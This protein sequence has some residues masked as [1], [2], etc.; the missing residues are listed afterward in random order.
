[1]DELRAAGIDN[2]NLDLMYALPGQDLAGAL[3]DIDTALA[4]APPHLSH[5]QLTMEPGTVFGALPPPDLPGDESAAL[6]MEQ[7]QARLA[8]AGF[9]HY[10]VSAYARAGAC[11]QH[12]LNYW[13]FG[14]YLG[15]GA[16]AHGKYTDLA[17]QRIV[18]TVREREPRRYLAQGAAAP[19]PALPVPAADLPFEFMMLSLIHI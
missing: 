5:Y 13:R 1:M 16:G 2:F 7:C 6:M 8:S 11:C 19:L 4:F 9:A 14:D 17:A 3:A 10:E 12:N 18:R 15:I